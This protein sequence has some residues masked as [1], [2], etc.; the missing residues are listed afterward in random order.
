MNPKRLTTWW[1][2]WNDLNWPNPDNLD[3]VKRKAER[4]AESGATSAMLFGTH[5]RWDYLPY[6]TILHDYIAAVAEELGRY[7]VELFDHHSV[8]LIHRYDTRAEMRHVIHDSGPHL[9][10]SPSRE[11]AASWRYE[12]SLLNDWRMI[13]VRTGRPLFY[14]QYAS[15]G[16]C[17]RNPEFLEAYKSYVQRLI[18][19]TGIAGLSAD[20]PV[21][22]MHFASCACPHCRAELKK[23]TG[24]DLPPV[25]DQTFW[26]NWD[27][28]AWKAW[29]DL[30]L[31]AG[32]HFFKELKSVL[33]EGFELMTCGSDSSSAPAV[34][35]AADALRF[36]SGCTRINVEMVGNTPP[37]KNDPKTSNYPVGS[38]LVSSSLHQSVA[39]KT[40]TRCFG[41]GFA[42]VPETAN[43]VWAVNKTLDSDCWLIALKGRLGLPDHLTD[44]LPDES[45]IIGRAFTF[46]KE[47]PELFS[48][49][50]AGQMAVFF[51]YET[52]DHSLFGSIRDGIGADFRAALEALFKAGIS[53]HTITEFPENTAS[54]PLVLVPSAALMRP[55]EIEACMRYIEAGGKVL[56]TGPTALP[57]LPNRWKLPNAADVPPED[58]FL[59]SD[60]GIH[61]ISPKWMA[62]KVTPSDDP[63]VLVEALPGLFYHPGRATEPVVMD[64]LLPFIRKSVTPLPVN[65]VSAEGYFTTLFRNEGGLTVHFLAADYD[66]KLDE[67]LDRIRTH[68]SRV[69]YIVSAK[70][71]GVSRTVTIQA[72]SCPE[73][74]LPI[75]D[76]RAEVAG[77]N[78]LY[79][80]SLPENCSYFLLRF[81]D[82]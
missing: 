1:I 65:V 34:P 60:D 14:P 72:K 30:R 44:T 38:R 58:F 53:P 40:G 71:A 46:E 75:T 51:S 23:R 49:D 17:M 79:T 45:D 78:G 25:S 80:I 15:E 10:F 8:N 37:Y 64:A 82:R 76:G 3:S 28:P 43:L 26:G 11:A 73:V 13:D 5:F 12:G 50:Q 20:D 4:V 6:F 39:R 29:C 24:I 62:M 36:S 56:F 32:E 7:N 57:D 61:L 77:E 55:E 74:F 63:R 52:R 67:H 68:R 70:P 54:Y 19:D 35:K 42:F 27:N 41:T 66:T 48:G 33:P 69:N 81:R 2:R 59:T 18:A 31:D 47:H 22:Y 16:F 9:P 21:H